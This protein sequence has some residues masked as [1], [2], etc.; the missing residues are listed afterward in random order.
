MN[1]LHFVQYLKPN[2]IFKIGLLIMIC[3]RLCINPFQTPEEEAKLK[4]KR[5]F[6]EDLKVDFFYI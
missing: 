3:S 6:N 2:Q 1:Y 4:A 5:Q